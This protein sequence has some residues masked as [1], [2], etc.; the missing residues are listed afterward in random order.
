MSAVHTKLDQLIPAN[1]S[2]WLRRMLNATRA[3]KSSHAGPPLTAIVLAYLCA[4]LIVAG[5]W[6]FT[7]VGIAGLSTVS[8]SAPCDQLPLF[9]T[10]VIYNSMFSLVLTNPLAFFA[11]RYA[12]DELHSERTSGVFG[13]LVLG[14]ALVGLVTLAV[15][16]PF[17]GA[18]AD[19]NGP[20]ALGAILN[21]LLIGVSWLLIPFMG[22]LRAYPGILLAFAGGAAAMAGFGWVLDDPDPV[23][24]LTAFNASFAI[25]DAVMMACIVRRVG[26][27]IHLRA[28]ILPRLRQKWDLLACGTAYAI[29]I[30]ADKVIMWYGSPWHDAPEGSLTLAGVL[31]SMPNYDTAV[32]WAQLASI[33]VVSIAFV[34][35]ETKFK[36]VFGHFFDRLG[37]Q[38]SLRELTATVE[39]LRISIIS[40]VAMLFVALAIVAVSSVLFSFAFMTELGLKPG[41]M[42]ILRI[43]LAAMAFHSSAMFCFVFLLYLDLRRQ[44]LVVVTAYAVLNPL[45]TMVSL[46]LG[47]AY[48]GYGAMIAAAT[49]FILAFVVLLRE[50]PWLHY[51][52]FVTNNSSL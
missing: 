6:I 45:L 25:I 33:P 3:Q 52:A 14:L 8:C 50:L 29:G 41:Y 30:W 34:H 2:A 12:A 24:L 15:A 44:A 32:F 16:V 47:A 1:Q 20:A 26:C 38:A 43:S 10:I 40:G 23:T 13:I 39:K 9:R 49:T 7:M 35:V 4:A 51:H 5:P 17:Y 48:Y 42:S 27:E 21:A 28:D 18:A 46:N 19:L 22:A 11:G 36:A 31:H 37:N